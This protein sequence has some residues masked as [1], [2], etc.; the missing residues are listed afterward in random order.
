MTVEL[1][2]VSEVMVVDKTAEVVMSIVDLVVSVKRLR[3]EVVRVVRLAA[4][5]LS[6]LALATGASRGYQSDRRWCGLGRSRS[7]SSL[8]AVLEVSGTVPSSFGSVC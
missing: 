8:H 7:S 6:V 1:I 4:V 2:V 5:A 3:G